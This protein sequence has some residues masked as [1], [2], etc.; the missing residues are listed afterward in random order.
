MK[1]NETTAKTLI[2]IVTAI[3]L[4]VLAGL[5]FEAVMKKNYDDLFDL[6]VF[7]LIFFV[8]I[9]VLPLKRIGTIKDLRS[10][11][12]RIEAK[13]NGVDESVE[14]SKTRYE[15]I[16]IGKNPVNGQ[17]MQFESDPLRA[18]PT[19]Y[20]PEKI[21]IYIDPQDAGNYYMD[22]DFL[23]DINPED[24]EGELKS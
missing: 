13:V 22:I 7:A 23:D 15:I 4:L 24:E 10:S 14:D 5:I 3:V 2:Y 18:D 17:E 16:A 9:I 20:L 12:I 11:G 21:V 8:F 6:V 19:R 1:L